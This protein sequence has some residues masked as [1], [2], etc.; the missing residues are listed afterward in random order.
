MDSLI[1][2]PRNFWTNWRGRWDQRI[3]YWIYQS[4]FLR[5][6]G[7][8]RGGLAWRAVWGFRR[9]GGTGCDFRGG[10]GYYVII[11]ADGISAVL[12]NALHL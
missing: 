4:D 7:G 12:L 5:I 8:V 6:F 11:V 10:A 2:P 3:A 1:C 9:C